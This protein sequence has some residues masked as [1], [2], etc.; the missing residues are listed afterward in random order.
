MN[1]NKIGRFAI[2]AYLKNLKQSQYTVRQNFGIMNSKMFQLGYTLVLLQLVA[3]TH[4]L[5]NNI[6][7]SLCTIFRSKTTTCFSRLFLVLLLPDYLPSSQYQKLEATRAT[8]YYGVVGAVAVAVEKKYEAL[9]K[10]VTL[11]T[12]KGFLNTTDEILELTRRGHF[13]ICSTRL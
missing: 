11:C 7:H 2:F 5:M 10:Q 6:L 9:Q 8:G 1:Y 13:G 12:P 4:L 3:S